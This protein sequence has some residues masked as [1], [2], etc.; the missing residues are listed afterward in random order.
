MQAFCRYGPGTAYLHSHGLYTGDLAE[1]HGR[2]TSGTW[3]W[4]WPETLNRRC[5]AAASV[6]EVDGNILDVAV[7]RTELPK[8]S[9][10]GPPETV[11]AVRD[12]N[13]VT[14]AWSE[15]KMRPEDYRGYMI[16]ATVCQNGNLVTLAVQ[17]DHTSY[18]FTDERSCSG[19]SSGRLYAVEKHGYT[20]PVQIPWPE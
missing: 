13:Q 3:L 19:D 20:D 17:T 8:T 6:M 9:F 11:Q 18:T 14:V 15:V 1:V 2:N 16:E 4:I 10:V 12:G 5:W 7:V